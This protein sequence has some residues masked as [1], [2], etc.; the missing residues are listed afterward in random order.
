MT[1]P[2]PILSSP[3][4]ALSKNRNRLKCR[5]TPEILR[6]N[7]YGW[8]VPVERGVYTLAESGRAAL[9]RLRGESRQPVRRGRGR[10][11]RSG[12]R[13]GG[14]QGAANMRSRGLTTVAE[15]NANRLRLLPDSAFC[16]FQRL[17]DFSYR[18]FRFGVH[19]EFTQVVLGPWTSDC[20]LI[21]CHV[22]C[23]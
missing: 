11:S 2:T 23:S 17:R 13:G 7:V 5:R 21:F 6:G 8:F 14:Q 12:E 1:V 3:A 16:P 22:H 20:G 4:I 18:C 19:L 10:T 9:V 15:P